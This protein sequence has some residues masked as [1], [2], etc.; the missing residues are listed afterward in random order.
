MFK[1]DTLPAGILT[2]ITTFAATIVLI[3]FVNYL[4]VLTGITAQYIP[5][6]KLIPAGVI[7]GILLFRQMFVK[8]QKEKNGKGILLVTFIILVAFALIYL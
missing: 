4:L 2:G 6:Q 5:A 3:L 8:Y 7:P 1:N